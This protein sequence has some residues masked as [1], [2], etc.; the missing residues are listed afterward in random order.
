MTGFEYQVASHMIYE[1]LVD[2]A[3]TIVEAVRER[4]D[5]ERRNPWNE[6]ECGSHY[7]RAMSSYA[8]LLALSGFE[9]DMTV[10]EI[11]FTPV[12]RSVEEEFR[13][14]WALGT[15]WG[16]F[17]SRPGNM[18]LSV[19]DGE[20]ELNRFRSRLFGTSSKIVVLHRK[21]KTE[22][23]VLDGVACFN[24]TMVLAS[25]DKL[26]LNYSEEVSDEE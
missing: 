25:G 24:R 23:K 19:L 26:I 15:A 17:E 7:V 6:F 3:L 2:E 8:L 21:E 16:I 4:F 22:C 9:Y 13:C 1:G 10:Q 18:T 12:S 5:G 20:I 11:G 14:F